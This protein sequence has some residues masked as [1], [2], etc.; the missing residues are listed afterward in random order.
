MLETFLVIIHIFVALFLI[1]VVLVQGGHSGGIGAVFGGGNSSGLFGAGG[2]TS[3]LSKITFGAAI[4]FVITT[5]SLSL[6]KG[7]P[8]SL[9]LKEKL[10]KLN[11]EKTTVEESNKNATDLN[12]NKEQ[13]QQSVSTQNNDK[14]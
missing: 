13:E 1:L 3:L 10:E 6:I 5:L 14:K 11:I 12:N 7:K 2:A 4:I 9:N 8:S